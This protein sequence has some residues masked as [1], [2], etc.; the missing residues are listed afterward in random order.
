MKYYLTAALA[1]ITIAT[2]PAVATNAANTSGNFKE[3]LQAA[4][5]ENPEIVAEALT[6]FQNRREAAERE[7]RN[8]RVAEFRPIFEAA[9]P[10]GPVLGNP[11]AAQTVAEFLDYNCGYC[12]RMHEPVASLVAQNDNVRVVTIM[13]PILG[14]SSETMARFALAADLQGKFK[15]A[16]D[17][18]YTSEGRIT[19]D[20]E[21]LASIANEIGVNWTKAKADMTGEA[22]N[23]TLTRHRQIADDLEIRGTPFFVTP[24]DVHPGAISE[25][26]LMA[27]VN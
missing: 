9:D 13:L 19:P 23:A 12:R 14:E 1:A 20:D 5:R 18:F 2:V 8:Q 4:L 15:A 10:V 25:G 26:Q 17:Y 16:N 27:S 24:K 7:A 21:T 11:D 3:Q 6:T 22:V